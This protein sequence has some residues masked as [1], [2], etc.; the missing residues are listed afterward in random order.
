MYL[1]ELDFGEKYWFRKKEKNNL[2]T[3]VLK[4]V[5]LSRV[6]L[7]FTSPSVQQVNSTRGPII[8]IPLIRQIHTKPS[9]PH[10]RQF[11]TSVQHK[12]DSSTQNCQFHTI[13]S[14]TSQFSTYPVVP[15]NTVNS[16]LWSVP[17]VRSTQICQA[18]PWGVWGTNKFVLN[19][20]VYRP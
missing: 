12:S 14:S 18:N 8:Y 6:T 17:H 16:T 9:N 10:F 7:S 3:A 4:S 20:R 11:H 1:E 2:S 15:H 19:W 5:D 13:V